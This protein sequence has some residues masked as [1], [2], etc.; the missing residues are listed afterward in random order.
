ML[1]VFIKSLVREVEEGR[2][3]GSSFKKTSFERALNEVTKVAQPGMVL[4]LSQLYNKFSY[5]K[6][7][8]R[9]WDRLIQ[10]SGFELDDRGFI[11]GG[12]WSFVRSSMG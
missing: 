10:Q 4:Q 2:R 8:W 3:A 7:E 5:L 12:R 1:E 6:R 9:I 11:Q